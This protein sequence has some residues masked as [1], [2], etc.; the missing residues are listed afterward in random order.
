M[1]V[2]AVCPFTVYLGDI[3]SSLGLC[4]FTPL[5]AASSQNHTGIL[6]K[7][8]VL[9]WWGLLLGPG[10]LI[11]VAYELSLLCLYSPGITAVW[12]QGLCQ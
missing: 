5:M 2:L 4:T 7:A 3:P 1:S 12:K 11:F 9:L 6:H 10:V 8:V